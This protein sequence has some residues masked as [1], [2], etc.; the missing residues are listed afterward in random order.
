MSSA[1]AWAPQRLKW[2]LP[3]G[4]FPSTG[5]M[6]GHH[7]HLWPHQD[8]H[9]PQQI[10]ERRSKPEMSVHKYE[11]LRRKSGFARTKSHN[12]HTFIRRGCLHGVCPGKA[13]E[14]TSI[15]TDLLC[16]FLPL[17]SQTSTTTS[18]SLSTVLTDVV[19]FQIHHVPLSGSV[20]SGKA[21]LPR[22]L[23]HQ[24]KKS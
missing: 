5:E 8:P 6:V 19:L 15:P 3:T 1:A 14:V 7:K 17:P 10:V 20:C 12:A 21:V 23:Q 2:S 22:P 24:L 13:S 16:S 9:R 11:L 18:K 4:H